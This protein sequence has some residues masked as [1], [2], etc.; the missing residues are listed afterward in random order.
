MVI[1]KKNILDI[2]ADNKRYGLTTVSLSFPVGTTIT[3]AALEAARG[4]II[5]NVK[6]PAEVPKTTKE[7]NDYLKARAAIAGSAGTGESKRRGNSR[8]YSKLAKRKYANDP[9]HQAS[10]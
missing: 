1:T 9:S 7:V 10:A 3:R 4:K 2:L 6:K 8:Y 5:L